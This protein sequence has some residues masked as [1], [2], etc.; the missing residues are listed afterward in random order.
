[1]EKGELCLNSIYML[2]KPGVHFA[3]AAVSH[4]KSGKL[5]DVAKNYI[6]DS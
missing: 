3:T 2:L 4:F 5:L 1:M 6:I